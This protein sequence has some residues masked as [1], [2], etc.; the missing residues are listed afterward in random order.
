[1]NKSVRSKP[2]SQEEISLF[3]LMGQAMLNIQIL[4]ECLG[5]SITLK[6][7]IGCSHK[8]SKIDANKKLTDRLKYTLGKAVKEASKNS[9]Y[10]TDLQ[11]SL[12]KIVTER[13]WLVHKIVNDFYNPTKRN[14]LFLKINSI[15]I[16]AHN[17]QIAIENDLIN[18]SE[19]KGLDMT[20]VKNE[21]AKWSK[22]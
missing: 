8:L 5:A 11:K 13:N 15:A 18:F 3:T 10:P 4:E 9:L 2:A 21:I 20:S 17:I 7:D 6:V 22:E 1:M 19:K 14:E 12:E 16:A